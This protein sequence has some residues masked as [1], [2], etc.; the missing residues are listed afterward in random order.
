MSNK[1][2]KSAIYNKN[3]VCNIFF[4]VTEN[5]I[6]ELFLEFYTNKTKLTKKI[7]KNSPTKQKFVKC[8]QNGKKWFN[9]NLFSCNVMQFNQI[10]YNTNVFNSYYP[11][12]LP[13]LS[14]TPVLYHT[15]RCHENVPS[16]AKLTNAKS[17]CCPVC[18]PTLGMECRGRGESL[19]EGNES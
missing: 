12:P 7:Q 4:L 19:K 18:Q 8:Y 1:S 13:L 10:Q 16:K 2:I 15:L 9:K 3:F 11:S 14:K 17:Y 5:F 6:F